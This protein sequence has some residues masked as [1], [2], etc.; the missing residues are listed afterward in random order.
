M[1]KS[2]EDLNGKIKVL[3]F[4]IGKSD[5]I[6]AK[7]DREA[8]KRQRLSDEAISSMLDTLKEPIEENVFSQSK[9][10]EEVKTWTQ[11]PEKC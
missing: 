1:E 10:N 8:L 9:S 11:T 3:K 2:L 5:G 4:R 6:R 7:G